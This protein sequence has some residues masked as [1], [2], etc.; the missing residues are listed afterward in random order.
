VLASVVNATQHAVRSALC[1]EDKVAMIDVPFRAVAILKA[2]AGQEQALL[3]FTLQAMALIRKVVACA[4][5]R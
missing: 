2:K 4:K 1:R 3:D 5:W